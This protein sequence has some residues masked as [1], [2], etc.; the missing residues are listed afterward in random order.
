MVVIYVRKKYQWKLL[1]VN[2]FYLGVKL[3]LNVSNFWMQ[4]VFE[5]KNILNMR[6]F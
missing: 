6:S 1:H 2:Q 5:W 4:Q 3:I